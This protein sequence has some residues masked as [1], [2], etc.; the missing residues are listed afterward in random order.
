M[1]TFSTYPDRPVIPGKPS[2]LSS[3]LS[4][5]AKVSDTYPL[6]MSLITKSLPE[7]TAPLNC[8]LGWARQGCAMRVSHPVLEENLAL[9]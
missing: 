1:I 8:L 7:C 3:D 5:G 4:T 9:A 2:R 6:A